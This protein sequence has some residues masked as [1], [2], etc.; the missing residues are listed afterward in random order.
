LQPGAA[1]N[2]SFSNKSLGTIGKVHSQILAGFD[3]EQDAFVLEI[4]LSALYPLLP[5][6]KHF[7]PL[8]KYPATTRD[9]TLIVDKNI[10]AQAILD[11]LA[12]TREKL[13]EDIFLFDVFEGKPI[14]D[15]KKSLSLRVTY[16]SYETTLE[17][18]S[19]NRLHRDLTAKLLDVFKATLPA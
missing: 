10:E 6:D 18:E 14:P 16:R 15:G 3:L 11:S 12:A 13:V 4:N 5:D 19:V 9:I 2:I 17:D 1:A 7:Q 8:S